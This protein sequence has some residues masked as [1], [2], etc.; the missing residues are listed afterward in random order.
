VLN[1][2]FTAV[3][4][5]HIENTPSPLWMQKWLSLAGMRP[6]N[7]IVDITNY[8]MK[9][10]GQPV[11]AF[12]FDQILPN[13]K[14]IPTM[15]LRSS[16]KGEKIKTLDGKIHTLPGD[17]IVI[18]DG[19]GRLIDLCG[20]MGG[21]VSHITEQTTRMVLFVQTY[22]PSHIRKTSM[23]LSHRTEAAALFEKGIDTELVLPTLGKGI[24][25]I[26][27][28]AKG[29]IQSPLY[30]L[31]PEPYKPYT[32]SVL[33]SKIDMYVGST[34]SDHDIKNT[35]KPLGLNPT[36]T[37]HLVTVSVPS[38]RKDIAID[39]DIIEEISRI[40]GYHNIKTKLPDTE[41][42]LVF[43]D[44]ILQVENT[45][46]HT[47][48][49]WGYTETMTYSM[50]SQKQMELFH[51]PMDSAYRISNPLSVEWEYM[52]PTLVPSMLTAI[53]ENSSW[54]NELSLFEIS[55]E[56]H[57]QNHDLPEE[58]STLII[59]KT[60]DEFYSLK[61]VAEALF[62]SFGIDFPNDEG[63]I[64]SW[65]DLDRSLRL[66]AYGIL[67]HIDTQLLNAMDIHRPVV[68]LVID[69]ER[70][71]LAIKHAN[72]YTPIP[73]YPASFEDIALII[74]DK[75]LIGPMMQDIRRVDPLIINVTLLDR[76][77]NI[78]TF[79]ITYQSQE[80]N[81]TADDIQPIREKVLRMLSETYQ[82]ELKNA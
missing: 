16:K 33:K 82:A 58:T 65:F 45:I 3:V 43:E 39:V 62:S 31:Y 72:T 49:N 54:K 48:K 77:K 73:K 66:G 13:E 5:D 51:I 32:V 42:P 4:M 71:M 50:I 1:P 27:Q 60:G 64:A 29:R 76:Y 59:A 37:K 20:I 55:M 68:V 40:Y 80:K 46:K 53:K 34:L 24:E 12:D 52:R 17:D 74:P 44:P 61:G 57:K 28:H 41:P 81:L 9:A 63:T 19:S 56:Y 78:R 7:T 25:L 35:L 18:E 14:G 26:T 69:L 22:D 67:G 36:I 30:D 75:T 21:G 8:L 23:A 2:R 15:I 70:L 11:H 38:F 47:L 79:H 10:Y 6:I